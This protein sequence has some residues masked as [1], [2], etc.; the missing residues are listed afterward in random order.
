[1]KNRLGSI[2]PK[3]AT[4]EDA[5][6]NSPWILKN[7]S[8]TCLG[9]NCEKKNTQRTYY[10]M[11]LIMRVLLPMLENSKLKLETPYVLDSYLHSRTSKIGGVWFHYGFPVSP[12]QLRE[13]EEL[14]AKAEELE[15]LKANGS[16]QRHGN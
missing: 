4:K 3:S 12:C 7:Q 10:F 13:L 11:V 16:P 14:R 6:R 2:M 1:M 15:K 8:G 5:N 9:P